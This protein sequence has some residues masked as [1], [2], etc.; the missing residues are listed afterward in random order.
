MAAAR[1]AGEGLCDA[2]AARA[3]GEGLCD[4]TAAVFSGELW[5]SEERG[6]CAVLFLMNLFGMFFFGQRGGSR[7]KAVELFFSP[8]NWCDERCR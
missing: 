5:F 2:T 8:A 1:A 3:A 6:R 4:A 7:Y